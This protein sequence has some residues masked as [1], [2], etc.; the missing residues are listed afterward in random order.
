VREQPNR[1]VAVPEL[2][3]GSLVL[4][5]PVRRLN[6]Q[7]DL[8]AVRGHGRGDDRG[9]AT[10]ERLAQREAPAFDQAGAGQR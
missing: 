10:R 8:V 7:H 3:R 1:A 9:E 5:L 6:L 2:E 4:A